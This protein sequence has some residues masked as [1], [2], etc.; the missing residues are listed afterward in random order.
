LFTV[1]WP[2]SWRAGLQVLSI[3]FSAN[4]V[5]F[6]CLSIFGL[7]VYAQLG[8]SLQVMTI[9]QGMSAV[10]T[11]VKWPMIGQLRS[12]QEIG[13][14]RDVLRPRL[15]LQSATFIVLAAIALGAG[16]FL[17]TRWGGGKSMLPIGWLT[18]LVLNAFM[19]MQ[20]AFWTHLLSTENRI[21]SLW[22]TVVTY[23]SGVLLTFGLLKLTPLGLGAVVLGPLIAGGM[24]NYWYWPVVG[25]KS[26]QTG[27]LRFTFFRARSRLL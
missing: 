17:L 2:N 26:L 8:L 10:W 3:Y 1:I 22:A 9:I 25:A 11:L 12:R 24:F 18:L 7:A 20:F 13:R 19:E 15:A 27:W 14:I 16:P 21:P 6:L 4:A 5:S 23:S